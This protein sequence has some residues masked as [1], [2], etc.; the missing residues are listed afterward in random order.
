MDVELALYN[1]KINQ[2]MTKQA[3][4]DEAIKK[5]ILEHNIDLLLNTAKDLGLNLGVSASPLHSRPAPVTGNR[6][7]VLGST[8][9]AL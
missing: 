8:P 9:H 4:L 2:L 6:C 5:T 3:Q 1:W 7:T